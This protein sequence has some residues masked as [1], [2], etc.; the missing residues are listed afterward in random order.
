MQMVLPNQLPYLST[1]LVKAGAQMFLSQHHKM[2]S[3]KRHTNTCPSSC[4]SPQRHTAH[5]QSM[6]APFEENLN[7]VM[8]PVTVYHLTS[9]CCSAAPQNPSS[10]KLCTDKSPFSKL[11]TECPYAYPGS[12]RPPELLKLAFCQN[13]R[14]CLPIRS[15]KAPSTLHWPC[16][17]FEPYLPYAL[18]QRPTHI[19]AVN[20]D[21]Y[22]AAVYSHIRKPMVD[23]R[24][25][26]FQPFWFGG[27]GTFL[28]HEPKGDWI[29]FLL[30][31]QHHNKDI[32]TFCG[33]PKLSTPPCSKVA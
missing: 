5:S 13:S 17:I 9:S 25:Q 22:P 4:S 26:S 24:E 12:V 31:F 11:R 28:G 29:D 3:Q 20:S 33:S 30:H 27:F 23:L 10:S 32:V 7:P 8:S 18:C 16:E 19:P 21:A 2:I 1:H 14:R 15:L 6:L